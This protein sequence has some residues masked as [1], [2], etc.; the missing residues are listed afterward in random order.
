MKLITLKCTGCGGN[1]SVDS[2][3]GVC[4]CPY[5]GETAIITESDAVKLKELELKETEVREKH[6]TE[7]MK[8]QK[9]KR[10]GVFMA[11]GVIVFLIFVYFATRS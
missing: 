6:R 3:K 7:Q 2:S 5:C 9:E 8:T 11:I 10:E 4:K 1:Y